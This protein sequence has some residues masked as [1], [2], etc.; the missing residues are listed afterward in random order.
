MPTIPV[1][2]VGA[3]PIRVTAT[4][5]KLNRGL[6]VIADPTNTATGFVGNGNA[7][8][9]GTDAAS[10]IPV[11]PGAWTFVPPEALFTTNTGQS[12]AANA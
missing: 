4:T 7:I 9:P 1:T 11:F 8:T 3:T 5:T 12:D 10:G 2:N 6:L